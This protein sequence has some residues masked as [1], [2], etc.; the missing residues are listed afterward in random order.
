MGFLKQKGTILF[1]VL[2]LMMFGTSAFAGTTDN[3]GLASSWTT[4]STWFSDGYMLKIIS[5]LMLVFAITLA[6]MK[7][8]LYAIVVLIITVIISNLDDVVAKFASA[9]F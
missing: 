9:I 6:T 2:F 1:T 7:Q 4:V 8:Y 3:L 5:F